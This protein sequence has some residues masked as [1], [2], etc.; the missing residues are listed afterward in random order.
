MTPSY[1]CQQAI[2]KLTAYLYKDKD[3]QTFETTAFLDGGV[4]VIPEGI[5]KSV[6]L[7]ISDNYREG[8]A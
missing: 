4:L 5:P 3:S 8:V 7:F 6:G 2:I 1:A